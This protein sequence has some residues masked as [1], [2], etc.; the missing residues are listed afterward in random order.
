MAL[1]QTRLPKVKYAQLA[2]LAKSN[3]RSIAAELRVAID[4][5]I[6]SQP[7]GERT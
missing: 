2:K 4:R 7:K 1:A 3:E 6:D 5:H